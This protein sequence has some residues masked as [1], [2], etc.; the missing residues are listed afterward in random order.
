[1]YLA[2]IVYHMCS[3]N[4]RNNCMERGRDAP[5]PAVKANAVLC[6]FIL[7]IEPCIESEVLGTV[8]ELFLDPEQLVVLGHAVCP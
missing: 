4:A 8:A 1:M 2:G 6:L 3:L 7:Q 5:A